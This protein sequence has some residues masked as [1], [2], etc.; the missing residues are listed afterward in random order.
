MERIRRERDEERQRRHEKV[1][2]E[3]KSIWASAQ[4]AKPEQGYLKRK[5]IKPHNL[6]QTQRD[7]LDVLI[8]EA[9]DAE[10]TL[11]NLQCIYPDQREKDKLFLKGGRKQG[12]FHTF[13]EP[14][15]IRV[16]CEGIATAASLHEATGYCVHST[17]DCGNLLPV[18][19][20]L[21]QSILRIK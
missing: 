16:L 5:G 1:K 11:W 12:C 10:G 13:G 4:P 7:G 3:A 17:F 9:R 2:A 18:A 20:A 14:S 19:E 6:R 8:V 21:R 15:E